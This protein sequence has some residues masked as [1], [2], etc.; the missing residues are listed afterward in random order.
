MCQTNQTDTEPL[1]AL[2]PAAFAGLPLNQLIPFNHLDAL[3]GTHDVAG[4]TGQVP[5]VGL[6]SINL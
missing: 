1:R 6:Q 5:M 3:S 4:S 2:T